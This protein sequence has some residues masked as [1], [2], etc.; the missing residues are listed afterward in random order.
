MKAIIVQLTVP[1]CRSLKHVTSSRRVCFQFTLASLW[2]PEIENRIM[3]SGASGSG[4]TP[5]ITP[6]DVEDELNISSDVGPTYGE[7][8]GHNDVA[9]SGY[10][11]ESSY[12]GNFFS[13]TSGFPNT[14]LTSMVSP[15][16]F[17]QDNQYSYGNLDSPGTIPPPN[18]QDQSP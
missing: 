18:Y 10:S 5:F 16:Y 17:P 13:P 9:A 15:T 4:W 14:Q 7:Y 6:N 1:I 8:T 12:A 3:S 11:G 2:L